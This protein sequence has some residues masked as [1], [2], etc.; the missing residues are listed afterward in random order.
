MSTKVEN[1]EKESNN[2]EEGQTGWKTNKILN[3]ENF[4]RKIWNLS[5]MIENHENGLNNDKKSQNEW[6][7]KRMLFSIFS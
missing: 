7:I 2:D 5:K 3:C 4:F 6:K 1:D